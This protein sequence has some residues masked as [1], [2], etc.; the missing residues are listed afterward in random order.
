MSPPS[1][2]TNSGSDK[3]TGRAVLIALAVAVLIV[4]GYAAFALFGGDSVDGADTGDAALLARVE[5]V[6]AE[7]CAACHGAKLEGQGDW[8]VRN[9]DGTLPAP[10]HDASGHTWHHPDQMLF[11]YTQKG[12]DALGIPGF[13]SA[14]PASGQDFGGPLTDKDIWAVLSFIKSTWPPEVRSRQDGIN[15]RSR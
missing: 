12:G 14:M 9:P 3:S 8:R 10:P 4:G 11:D 13:K 7:N 6:Y 15:Q 1:P 5:T 2:A